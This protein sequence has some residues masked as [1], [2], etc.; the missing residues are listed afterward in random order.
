MVQISKVI[1]PGALSSKAR[2]R[3]LLAGED[4]V[5]NATG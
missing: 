3:S 5:S 1:K 2:D 4:A